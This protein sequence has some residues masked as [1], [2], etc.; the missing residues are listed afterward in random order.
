MS[1]ATIKRPDNVGIITGKKLTFTP[2]SKLFRPH[3][4]RLPRNRL[5]WRR[6]VLPPGPKSLLRKPF[7][8]IVRLAADIPYIGHG[9][10]N[11]SAKVF[12][13]IYGCKT[14]NCSVNL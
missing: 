8:T 14:A 11:G 5:W 7:I 9:V 3:H 12:A 2:Q 10:K 13:P 1:F 6:R 4:S